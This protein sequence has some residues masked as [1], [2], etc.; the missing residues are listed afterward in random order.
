MNLKPFLNLFKI[1]FADASETEIVEF[2]KL[3]GQREK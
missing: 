1:Y 3:Y 2:T